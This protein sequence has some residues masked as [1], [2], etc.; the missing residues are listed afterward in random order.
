MHNSDTPTATATEGLEGPMIHMGIAE[1]GK[2]YAVAGDHKLALLYLR[3]AMHLAVE[4]GDPEVFFRVYLEAALESMERLGYFEEVLSYTDKAID[5]YAGQSLDHVVARKDLA[6]IH[7]KRGV[8]LLKQKKNKEAA[9]AFQTAIDLM[10]EKGQTMPLSQT[11]LRW[12]KGGLFIDERRILQEQERL[13][14]FSVRADTVNP[15]RAIKLPNEN[16]LQIH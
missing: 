14:Y 8:I 12:A 7:Q 4:A 9:A 11:L 6:S 10:T 16:M 15:K 2:V 13:H 1:Q 3:H 5:L